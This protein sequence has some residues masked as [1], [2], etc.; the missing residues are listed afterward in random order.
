MSSILTLPT[1]LVNSRSTYLHTSVQNFNQTIQEAGLIAVLENKAEQAERAAIKEIRRLKKRALDSEEI[2]IREM[3]K[4][5]VFEGEKGNRKTVL[6]FFQ[7]V[8]EKKY[9]SPKILGAISRVKGQYKRTSS[10]DR[11]KKMNYQGEILPFVKDLWHL[12]KNKHPDLAWNIVT[13]DIVRVEIANILLQAERNGLIDINKENLHNY[14]LGLLSSNDVYVVQ[15][16][17]F[18]LSTFDY[19]SDVD[20]I[21]SIAKKRNKITFRK[22]KLKRSRIC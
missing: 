5:G 7:R 4:E 8:V 1:E 11:L 12:K 17:I 10:N 16:S 9:H 2:F 22:T 3:V 21:L 19:N 6:E 18:T 15:K 13:K 20:D 14:I